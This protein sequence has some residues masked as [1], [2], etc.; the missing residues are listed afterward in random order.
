LSEA[1]ACVA[2]RLESAMALA[3]TRVMNLR[4]IGGV[5]SCRG[6][7]GLAVCGGMA[8]VMRKGWGESA[9]QGNNAGRLSDNHAQNG[10][11]PPVDIE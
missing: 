6:G 5:L 7:G 4:D 1:A 10:H 3:V 9:M 11:I 8:A 2:V